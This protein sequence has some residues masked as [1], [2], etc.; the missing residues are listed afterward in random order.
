MSAWTWTYVKAKFIPEDIVIKVCD[1]SI[2]YLKGIWFMD[3]SRSS[4][5]ILEEWLKMHEEDYDYFTKTCKIDPLKLTKEY[6]TEDLKRKQTKI[7]QELQDLEEVKKGNLS[8]DW[9]ARKYKSWKDSS[10]N[11]EYIKNTIWVE[12]PEIFRYRHYSDMYIEDGLKTI[13]DLLGY[14]RKESD[15]ERIYDYQE[16]PESSDRNNGLT[17][18]L[19]QRIRE[20]YS[21][22]GDNNFSVHFG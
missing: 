22:F 14:L 3:G 1:K 12:V 15:P 17:P 16:D 6:L 20:H 19:E 4:G 5:D 7:T 8:L 2:K 11:C 18:K 10:L 21:R 13:D 9:F